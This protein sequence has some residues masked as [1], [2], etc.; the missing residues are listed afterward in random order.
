MTF[1]E[2]IKIS[3]ELGAMCLIHEIRTLRNWTEI[4]TDFVNID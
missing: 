4:I 2:K 3:K 1:F